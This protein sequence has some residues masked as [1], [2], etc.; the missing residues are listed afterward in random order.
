[1]IQPILFGHYQSHARFAGACFNLFHCVALQRPKSETVKSL[2]Y[3]W[4]AERAYSHSFSR[5]PALAT[6]PMKILGCA[7]A[8][9]AAS[10]Y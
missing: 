4:K 7:F 6:I 2:G 10:T 1:M 9:R 8:L 5:S 3:C